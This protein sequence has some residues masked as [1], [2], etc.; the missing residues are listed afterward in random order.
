MRHGAPA[1]LAA[2]FMLA[3]G[4]YSPRSPH[5]VYLPHGEDR[6]ATRDRTPEVQLWLSGSSYFHRGE[7]A[8]VYFRTD[9]DAYVFVVRIDTDGRLRV[10]YPESPFD[11]NFVRGGVTY[12]APGYGR[13]SFYVDDYPG[14]GYVFAIASWRRLELSALRDGRGWDYQLI[15]DRVS[16]DPFAIVH[17]LAYR[18]T[19]QREDEYSLDYAEYQVDRRA[20]YPRFLCYGCHAFRSYS[21]W[22]PYAHRCAKFRIVI[23]DDPYFYPYRYY[24]GTRVVYVREQRRWSHYQLK[25]RTGGRDDE[26]YI[27]RRRRTD[28]GGGRRSTPINADALSRRTVPE[29]GIERGRRTGEGD[30]SVIRRE[31]VRSDPGESDLSGRV[32]RPPRTEP[33]SSPQRTGEPPDE[34]RDVP[35]VSRPPSA[36]DDTPR[37]ITPRR[38]PDRDRPSEPRRSAPPRETPRRESAPRRESEPRRES[39]PPKQQAPRQVEPRRPPP[40]PRAEP[41]R[42][43][44]P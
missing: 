6:V 8:R 44:E 11:D 19:G 38:E 20:E 43:P 24:Q 27:E 42:D 5:T 37:D 39:S 36:G 30:R 14:L 3:A 41:R 16:R 9:D 31:P 25:E 33:S 13:E 35:A 1:A 18:L 29:G 7:R 26:P 32:I 22:D 23:Y 34:P 12:R 40:A 2:T 28:D 17:E 4:C 10:L 15:G 21:V